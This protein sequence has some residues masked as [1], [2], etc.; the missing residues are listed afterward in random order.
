MAVGRRGFLKGVLGAAAAGLSTK[1]VATETPE[2]R[3]YKS[4]DP[5][6]LRR[7]ARVETVGTLCAPSPGI[8]SY[9]YWSRQTGEFPM[10]RPRRYFSGSEL[11]T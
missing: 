10:P 4:D 5:P 2:V 11:D 7:E 6:V 1:V 9:P 3:P 8:G